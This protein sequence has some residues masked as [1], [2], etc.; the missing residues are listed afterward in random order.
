MTFSY[1]YLLIGL[2]RA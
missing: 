2:V 1:V